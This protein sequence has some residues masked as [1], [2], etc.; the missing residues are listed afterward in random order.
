MY[1]SIKLYFLKRNQF[2]F[3]L[4]INETRFSL[5]IFVFFT[6]SINL[7]ILSQLISKYILEDTISRMNLKADWTI[8]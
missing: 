4:K 5:M 1:S 6:A 8:Y 7:I 3:S 2:V